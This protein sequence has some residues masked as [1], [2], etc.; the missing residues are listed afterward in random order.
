MFVKQNDARIKLE[1]C[2]DEDE[3]LKRLYVLMAQK[4]FFDMNTAHCN[5]EAIELF[6]RL[7][8]ITAKEIYKIK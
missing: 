4:I 7:Y 3:L 1:Y 2:K 5:A 6:A 8:Q